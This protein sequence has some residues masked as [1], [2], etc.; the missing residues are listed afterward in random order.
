MGGPVIKDKLFYFFNYEGYRER[1]SSL[2]T[3]PPDGC[4]ADRRFL[5]PE[6]Q[7]RPADPDLRPDDHGCRSGQP[8]KLH[9]PAFRGQRHSAEPDQ[10]DRH[11]HPEVLSAAESARPQRECVPDQPDADRQGL[12]QRPHRLQPV[13][14]ATTGRAASPRTT[15]TWQFANF[16]DNIA[17]VDG[18]AI[19]IPRE[20]AYLSYTDSISSDAAVRRPRRVQSSDR[21]VQYSE[22]GLRHHPARHARSLLNQSQSAPGAKQGTFP[23]LGVSD[24]TTFGGTNASA[25]HT[26]SGT[27]SA[28]VTKILGAQTL[29]AGY[30]FRL[31]QR[32]VF[33]INSPVGNYSFNRGFTQGPNPNQ[34]S[35]TSG[36]SVAS[37]LLGTPRQRDSRH[38]RRQHHTLKYQALFFQ[39][40]WKV[41]RKL[42]LN[43]GLRWEKEGSPTDRYN[44]FSN[45]DPI[46][47]FSAAGSRPEPEGRPVYPGRAG[48]TARSSPAATRTSSRVSASPI[49]STPRPCCA[50]ATASASCRRRSKATTARPSDSAASPPW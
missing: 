25:N 37:L 46:D 35:A 47:R 23:R 10:P 31:Y 9:P 29:K 28:T 5:R 15:S 49:S 22:P 6:D 42:T 27:A 7:R 26:V 32:N 33:G 12:L 19:L 18:R 8:R 14:H 34:A 40:D 20:S 21:G 4:A 36:Y 39:D 3:S 38:Q 41:S 48:A 45:F 16:F 30:E 17:D 2:E 1:T 24:L 11:E 50:A 43:L 44:M 13:A